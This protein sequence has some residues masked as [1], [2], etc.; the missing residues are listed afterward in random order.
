MPRFEKVNYESPKSYF[1]NEDEFTGYLKDHIE[2]L[3]DTLELDIEPIGVG[4]EVGDFYADLVGKCSDGRIVVIE[5]QFGATDHDH[6]GKLI[7]YS[8]GKE[9]GIVVWLAPEFREDHISAVNWLNSITDERTGFFALKVA[10]LRIGD[11]EPALQLTVVA[12]PDE[13]VR[14]IREKTLTERQLMY[15]KFFSKLSKYYIEK[16]PDIK[17]RSVGYDNSYILL[18][19]RGFS[20]YFAFDRDS[21]FRV[22]LWIE[23]GDALENESVFNELKE[24]KDDIERK[25]EEE[26]IFSGSDEVKRR[27][28][29]VYYEGITVYAADDELEELIE[30]ATDTMSKFISALNPYIEII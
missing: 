7:T 12:Q 2:Y 11:S 22:A 10:V 27:L 18:Y 21:K 20:F 19:K 25:V 4:V 30:W 26:V 1:K 28:I 29:A 9:A 8:A 6:L 14:E 17:Q 13:W 5:N 3:N 24:H 15:N 16:Y 23:T